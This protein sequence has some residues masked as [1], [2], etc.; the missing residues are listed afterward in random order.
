MTYWKKVIFSFKYGQKNTSNDICEKFNLNGCCR[1][2][3]LSPFILPVIDLSKGVIQVEE[4]FMDMEYPKFNKT[5]LDDVI[6]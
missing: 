3:I 5:K 4:E 1:K 6:D 2:S